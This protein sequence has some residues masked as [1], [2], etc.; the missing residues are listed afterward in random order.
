MITPSW[1]FLPPIGSQYGPISID[2][3]QVGERQQE[4]E[5]I[6]AF[7]DLTGAQVGPVQR[8][9]IVPGQVQS[10]QFEPGTRAAGSP[11]PD[12]IPVVTVDADGLPAPPIQVSAEVSS[13]ALGAA[14]EGD[15]YCQSYPHH[16][17][18]VWNSLQLPAVQLGPQSISARQ[19]MR[20]IAQA[21]GGNPCIA[22]LSFGNAA[23]A[24]VGPTASVNLEPGQAQALDLDG[25]AVGLPF[26][27]I[28]PA[29]QMGSAPAAGGAVASTCLVTSE[30]FDT[31]TGLPAGS[32]TA[33][34]Q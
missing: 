27:V 21:A 8:V 30:V 16:P 2:I 24:P 3:N 12:V 19:N 26:A 20:L 22:T 5:A 15:D 18:L 31:H 13:C 1:A 33:L 7:K 34:Y 23:G 6:V 25:S 9:R 29:V 17:H 32:Q 11:H 10:V 14:A 28:L 4:A